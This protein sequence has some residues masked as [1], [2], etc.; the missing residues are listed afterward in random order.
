MT[1]NLLNNRESFINIKK[2]DTEKL[3]KLYRN[4]KETLIRDELIERHLYIAEILSKNML[5]KV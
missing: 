2:I 5:I 1:D 3:F 4:S